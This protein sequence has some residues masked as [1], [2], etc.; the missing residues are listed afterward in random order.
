MGRKKGG[1]GGKVVVE[2]R[3]DLESFKQTKPAAAAETGSAAT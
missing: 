2:E 1:R 3:G